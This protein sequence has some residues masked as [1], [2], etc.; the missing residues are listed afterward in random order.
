M[1]WL[2]VVAA[3]LV[4]APATAKSSRDLPYA[5]EPVW[6][7]LVRFLRVDEKLKLVEK[8]GDNGYVL[9]ELVDGKRTFSG[10]AELA[11]GPDGGR[12]VKLTIRINDRPSY[13][14]V[15]LLDRFEVKLR[16]ELGEPPPAPAPP[17]PPPPAAPPPEDKKP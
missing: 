2:L 6:S 9:F 14:E 15:G 8:D 13:M 4:A 1:R 7:S 17:A 5:Y 16:E 3:L 11:K 12:P 10:A